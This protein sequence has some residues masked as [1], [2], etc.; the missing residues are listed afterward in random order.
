ML[1]RPSSGASPAR[2]VS[3]RKTRPFARFLEKP[4]LVTEPITAGTL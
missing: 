4:Y 1:Y 3:A 2:I